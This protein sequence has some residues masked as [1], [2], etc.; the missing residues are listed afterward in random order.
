MAAKHAFER[1][2]P[3]RPPGGRA[4]GCPGYAV[5]HVKALE[6]GGADAPTNMQWQTVAEGKAKDRTEGR[7][8]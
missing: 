7:C 1:Q 6:C 5:D 3:C 8:R 2:H 4:D